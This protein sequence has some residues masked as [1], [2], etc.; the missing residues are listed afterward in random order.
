MMIR[1]LVC[2]L[3]VFIILLAGCSRSSNYPEAKVTVKVVDEL[4]NPLDKVDVVIGFQE[5][6]GREQGI[7][8]V[9]EKGTTG[10]D[11]VFSASRKAG[12]HI[13]FSA[14]KQ[15][16]YKS[17]GEYHFANS[18]HGRWQ[19]WN[20]EFKLVLRKNE[21]PVPMYARYTH[22]L[23]L[24]A[25]TKAIGFDLMKYDWVS[26]YGKGEHA[27][28]I[29]KLTGSAIREDEYNYKLEITFANKFDGIQLVKE[30]RSKGSMLK[31][32]RLAPETGYA[33]ILSRSKSRVPGEPP[34]EDTEE[35]NNYIFRIRSEVKN[36]K[37]IRAMYGKIQGDIVFGLGK[38]NKV[39]IIFKYYLNPDYSRNL[40]FDVKQNLFKNLES[41]EQVGLD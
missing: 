25:A 9:A 8:D 17:Y 11:G 36:G 24:P 23:I 13:G 7:K 1:S 29:F 41:L 39:P 3:P 32:P 38:P 37:L 12:N 21:N 10:V 19:P 4:S 28:F 18:V 35:A 20:P 30:D 27:D 14:E 2:V 6:K 31:L 5:P 33:G 26:P 16:Y 22:K 34:R 40:E 15:G